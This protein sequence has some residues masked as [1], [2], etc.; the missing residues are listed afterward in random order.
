VGILKLHGMYLPGTVIRT[1]GACTKCRR[2]ISAI[3]K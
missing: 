2:Q 3:E 1:G